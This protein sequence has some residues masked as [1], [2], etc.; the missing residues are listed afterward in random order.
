MLILQQIESA[1][2]LFDSVYWLRQSG[3]YQ[4]LQDKQVKDEF[5]F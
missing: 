4:K 3:V 1:Q 2:L 5:K